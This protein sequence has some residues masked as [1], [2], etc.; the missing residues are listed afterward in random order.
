MVSNH[1]TAFENQ[2]RMNLCNSK[3]EIPKAD[4]D[5]CPKI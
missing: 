3:I 4:G 1:W 5:L 2:F